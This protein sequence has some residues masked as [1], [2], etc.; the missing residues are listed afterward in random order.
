MNRKDKIEEIEENLVNLQ[1]T[2][3]FNEDEE[4]VYESIEESQ[5][6]TVHITECPNTKCN[7]FITI[8]QE[9]KEKGTITCPKC[10][11]ELNLES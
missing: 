6:E 4:E 9:D 5:E 10:E 11:K 7:I 3:E 8:T 1:K 2:C